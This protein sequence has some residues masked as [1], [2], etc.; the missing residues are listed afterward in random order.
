LN[1]LP[2]CFE[3]KFTYPNPGQDLHPEEKQQ[4]NLKILTPCR[5]FKLQDILLALQ[6]EY[7]VQTYFFFFMKLLSSSWIHRKFLPG[8]R[9]SNN[10]AVLQIRYP[11]SWIRDPGSRMEKSGSGINIL[12]PQHYNK[13]WTDSMSPDAFAPLSS[14]FATRLWMIVHSTPEPCK[15]TFILK[16]T[17]ILK[18]HCGPFKRFIEQL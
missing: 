13:V 14:N 15:R 17:F 12:D 9:H 1:L 5:N 10:P 18:S 8:S 7:P 6:R 2:N 4:K 16:I 3:F 11:I